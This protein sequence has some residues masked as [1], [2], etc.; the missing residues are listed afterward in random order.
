MA[1]FGSA[2]GYTMPDTEFGTD[3]TI[4]VAGNVVASD[5]ADLRGGTV[6]IT[7]NGPIVGVASWTGFDPATGD[8][9]WSYT[10]GA[11]AEGD[12]TV[13]ASFLRLRV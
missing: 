6:E 9:F 12:Y 13:R 3:E 4:V 2:D 11:L 1:A 5:L 7:V 10:L 8:N